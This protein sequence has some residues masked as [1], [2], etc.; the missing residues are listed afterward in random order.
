MAA[1]VLQLSDTHFAPEPSDL[2]FGRDADERLAVVLDAFRRS[3]RSVDLVL[4]TGD[5]TNEGTV[6]ASERLAETIGALGLPVLALPGNHDVSAEIAAAF[7]GADEAIVGGWWVVGFDTTAPDVISGTLDVDAALRRVDAGPDL[8]TLVA[9][10]HPPR[11]HST[12]E[13]FQLIGAED[14]LAGLGAR[15]KV[16]AVVSGHLHDHFEMAG[17]RGLPLIGCPSTIESISHQGDEMTIG[18]GP[19]G[20]L[21]LELADD[22]TFASRLLL[23]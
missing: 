8:P 1:T 23:A 15:P 13:Q 5:L 12:H 19:T 20:A 7:G 4:L 16:K 22:G 14:L 9:L 17:P 11:S 6:A 2:V 3:Q 10:H 21:L 18:D